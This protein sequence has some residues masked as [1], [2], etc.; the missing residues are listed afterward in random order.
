MGEFCALIVFKRNR[1]SA[2]KD[3][4]TIRMLTLIISCS[5]DDS[6]WLAA[7]LAHIISTCELYGTIGPAYLQL[8]FDTAN[9][10]QV[11]MFIEQAD[12]GTYGRAAFFHFST[13]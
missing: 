2:Q 3:C 12:E 11:K 8:H 4:N 13:V 5:G 7:Y 6:L 10:V 1:H 9:R